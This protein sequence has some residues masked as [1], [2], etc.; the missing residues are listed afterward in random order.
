VDRTET[1]AEH[2]LELRQQLAK[3]REAADASACDVEEDAEGTVIET[4][5]AESKRQSVE[6]LEANSTNSQALTALQ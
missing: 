3:A 6:T 4:I 5:A 1:L 2:L